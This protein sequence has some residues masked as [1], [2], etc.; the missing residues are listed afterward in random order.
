MHNKDT[1]PLLNQ[2]LLLA[3]ALS[4]AVTAV[5]ILFPGI[6]GV[7]FGKAYLDAKTIIVVYAVMMFAFSLTTVIAQYSLAIRNLRF[8]YLLLAVTV[9]E[10]AGVWFIHGSV[11]EVAAMLMGVNIVL[12]IIS[13]ISVISWRPSID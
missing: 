8:A 11:L 3:G 13:Y 2:G 5:L 12:F 1:R 7:L 9:L 4:G 6:V 10:M